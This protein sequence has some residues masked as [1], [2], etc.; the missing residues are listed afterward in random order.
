ML[1]LARLSVPDQG[2]I[3]TESRSGFTSSCPT[4]LYLQIPVTA[5]STTKPAIL[6]LT[7]QKLT[8]NDQNILAGLK[9]WL[10]KAKFEKINVDNFELCVDKELSGKWAPLKDMDLVKKV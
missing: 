10:S 9:D 3:D 2:A 8:G 7:T 1:P 4:L 6:H 5:M